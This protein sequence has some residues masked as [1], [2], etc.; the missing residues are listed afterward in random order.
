MPSSEFFIYWIP[1]YSSV[2]VGWKK[3]DC[4]IQKTLSITQWT[5]GIF[6]IEKIFI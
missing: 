2:R 1:K 6:L 5:L 4:A 3:T